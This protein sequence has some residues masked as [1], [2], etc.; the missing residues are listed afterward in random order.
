MEAGCQEG[1][2]PLDITL[3]TPLAPASLETARF[4]LWGGEALENLLVQLALGVG[5]GGKAHLAS[6]LPASPGSGQRHTGG[7]AAGEPG[8]A[9]REP[10]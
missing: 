3:G 2:Q 6:G 7:G 8:E 1:P 9:Q 5:A 4:P 10:Q